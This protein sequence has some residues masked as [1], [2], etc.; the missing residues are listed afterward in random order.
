MFFFVIIFLLNRFIGSLD[1]SLNLDIL[2]DDF[3]KRFTNKF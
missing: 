3:L 2:K 1:F